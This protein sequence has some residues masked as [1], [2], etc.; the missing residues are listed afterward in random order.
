[1]TRQRF[2][3]GTLIIISLGL[4]RTP[5]A[6][7]SIIV[8]AVRSNLYQLSENNFILAMKGVKNGPFHSLRNRLATS[9]TVGQIQKD[10]QLNAERMASLQAL[11]IKNFLVPLQP[12]ASDFDNPDPWKY[13]G[14]C[15][16][17]RALPYSQVNL[18]KYR[19]RLET[20]LKE[21]KKRGVKVIAFEIGNE[22]NTACYNADVP[23]RDATAP[24]TPDEFK[25]VY[26]GYANVIKAAVETVHRREYY[27]D[28]K[29]ISAGLAGVRAT[30]YN[31]RN[32]P[33]PGR[34]I[35]ALRLIPY[36]ASGKTSVYDL[37]DGIG[38][39]YYARGNSASIEGVRLALADLDRDTKAG[40]K[41][42]WI[43]EWFAGSR[44]DPDGDNLYRQFR[45]YYSAAIN[46][47]V[48]VEALYIMNLGHYAGGV[49]LVDSNY[50]YYPDIRFFREIIPPSLSITA[51]PTTVTSG[52]PTVIT[53]TGHNVVPNSCSVR[54]RDVEG[55]NFVGFERADSGAKII[56]SVPATR[57][58]T[59]SCDTYTGD[60]A[61]SDVTVTLK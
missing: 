17:A 4:L 50:N 13:P 8:G 45:E 48:R 33:H 25:L 37:I 56:E 58:F 11:G 22:I 57:T 21:M 23:V 41:P 52:G 53:W 35:D 6:A 61:S 9:L 49:N 18:S 42:Y 3:V 24:P 43:T 36:N 40:G 20:N 5:A 38:I 59:L 31:G 29:I 55:G 32:I 19:A 47:P 60:T 26:S 10:A 30:K 7:D 28:A 2:T 34:I 14:L 54:Y 15:E 51:S 44:N 46:A 12:A 27:P 1:M 16:H 39:H